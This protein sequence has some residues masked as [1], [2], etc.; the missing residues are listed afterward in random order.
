MLSTG[1]GTRSDIRTR[2][3]VKAG[4]KVHQ[5]PQGKYVSLRVGKNGG[6]ASVRG[7]ARGISLSLLHGVSETLSRERSVLSG[8]SRGLIV[9][10]AALAVFEP[11]AVAIELEDV[12]VVSKAIEQ[13]AS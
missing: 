2:P 7:S 3:S 9:T 8:F 13:R 4:P 12:N 1:R 6:L 5:W 10:D 11:E